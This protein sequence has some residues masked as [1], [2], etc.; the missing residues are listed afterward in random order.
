MLLTLLLAVASLPV[1]ASWG[2]AWGADSAFAKADTTATKADTRKLSS[3]LR[4]LLRSA[5]ADGAP[6]GAATGGASAV[7]R[8][9]AAFGGRT[10]CAFVQTRSE[11]DTVAIVRHGGRILASLGDISIASVPLD[12]VAPLSLERGVRRIEAQS[13]TRPLLDITAAKTGADLVHA[14]TRLPQAFDGSGVVVGLQDVGF[15]LTHPT[16]R[17]ADGSR[18]RIKRF[19]DQ[20][21]TDESQLYVGADY[22]DEASLLAK[23]ESRDQSIISH[24]TYTAGIAAGTGWQSPYRGI[25]PASDICLVSNAVTDDRPLISDTDLD[26]Y[27]YATDALG[28]K[29]IFDYAESLGRPCVINFSEGSLQDFRGDDVLYY[30]T[31]SR[32]TG[33]G[34]ILV[35]AAGNR[36][37]QRGYF[38]K[39]VGQISAGTFIRRSGNSVAFT[40]K[41]RD[42]AQLRLTAYGTERR[43]LNV[44]LGDAADAGSGSSADGGDGT[45]DGGNGT[46]DGGDADTSD[47]DSSATWSFACDGVAYEVKVG[48]YRSCYDE[49]DGVADVTVTSS[50]AGGMSSLPFSVEAVGAEAD[51]EFYLTS[52]YL[53]TNALAPELSA[54]DNTHCIL[55]PGSAPCVICVGATTYRTSFVNVA[56][57]VQTSAN[58]SNGMLAP[59]SSLGPTFDGRRKPDVVAPGTNVISSYGSTFIS[60]PG[61]PIAHSRVSTFPFEGRTYGWQADTGTSAAAPVVAGT[62]A[63]WLQANPQLTPDDVREVLAATCKRSEW[64]T[65]S[66]GPDDYGYGE[67]DAYRGLLHVL[68]V[69][70]IDGI[71][72][73]QPRGVTFAVEADGTVGLTLDAAATA[74]FSVALLDTAGRRLR[75]ASF[76]A[77]TVACRMAAGGVPHGVYVVQTDSK[78]SALR[79]SSLLRL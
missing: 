36:G 70:G 74:P 32:L 65:S 43:V 6:A 47:D 46:P 34:R 77:G 30:E 11:A 27:T 4:R 79:G 61:D 63:L 71:S 15:D 23:G 44:E 17:T 75:S 40:V 38:H 57:E 72:S 76:A 62:I 48:S 24:G 69:D 66:C 1:E 13:G 42:R 64:L 7:A 12:G 19:W 39:P 21:S 20:L 35:V 58:G 22:T 41:W 45:S 55:S 18:L 37:G 51:V 16:F 49:A 25:A 8:S 68:G 10:V 73:S 28:F 5:G 67:I 54:G 3:Q 50:T 78:D 33:P 31:L 52:G 26:K 53:T 56:G 14:G 9:R 59:Y 29:Y 60:Q 2:E